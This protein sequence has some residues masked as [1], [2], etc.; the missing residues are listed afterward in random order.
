MVLRLAENYPAILMCSLSWVSISETSGSHYGSGS[1]ACTCMCKALVVVCCLYSFWHSSTMK[2]GII[3][4]IPSWS[5]EKVEIILPGLVQAWPQIIFRQF[6][7]LA[8]LF[9]ISLPK[10]GKKGCSSTMQLSIIC[11]ISTGSIAKVEINLPELVQVG[12]QFILRQAAFWQHLYSEFTAPN[13]VKNAA[14][15]QMLLCII[16]QIATGSIAKVENIFRT[17][18]MV[19]LKSSWGN[20]PYGS[21]LTCF[22]A[23]N[24]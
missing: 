12:C 10:T 6:L 19:D 1:S 5:I 7:L 17:G 24:R 14:L 3:W 20:L 9:S 13:Q 2:F 4:Q 8:P 15:A 18:G 22:T 21:T 23:Q 11:Q 16:C